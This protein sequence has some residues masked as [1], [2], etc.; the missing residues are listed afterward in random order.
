ME[1][2]E[3]TLETIIIIIIYRYRETLQAK[4]T[5]RLQFSHTIKLVINC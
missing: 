2:T 4:V 3:T 5:H 1:N